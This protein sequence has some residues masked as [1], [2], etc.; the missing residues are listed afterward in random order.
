MDERADEGSDEDLIGKSGLMGGAEVAPLSVGEWLGELDAAV[1][2][3]H[4]ELAALRRDLSDEVRTGRLVV[5]EEDG[6]ERVLVDAHGMYGGVEVRSRTASGG[7]VAAALTALDA[8]DGDPANVAVSLT[9]RGDVVASFDVTATRRPRL[10][11]DGTQTG[12]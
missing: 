1:D 4:Q 3:L 9:D 11:I 5:V 2:L 8:G 10:W 12:P 7:A 6:F